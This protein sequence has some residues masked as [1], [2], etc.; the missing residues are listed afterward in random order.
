MKRLVLAPKARADLFPIDA[1]IV[2]RNP[3]AAQRLIERLI[4][5]MNT[6]ARTPLIGRTYRTFK[7]AIRDPP[8]QGSACPVPSGPP[9]RLI[10][11]RC[12]SVW[13][14]Q[15]PVSVLTIHLISTAH[16]ISDHGLAGREPTARR[17][18]FTPHCN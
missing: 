8:R 3:L 18:A 14:R 5:A 6:L 13:F 4:Q 9:I 10:M 15:I 17:C 16:L 7:R 12:G 1:Y 11:L 2:E